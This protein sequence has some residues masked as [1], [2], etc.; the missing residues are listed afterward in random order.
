MDSIRSC[1]ML[2]QDT[3]SFYKLIAKNKNDR[4][5]TP[6]KRKKQINPQQESVALYQLSHT[7]PNKIDQHL[8]NFLPLFSLP[9][10]RNSC[11]MQSLFFRNFSLLRLHKDHG[12]SNGCMVA[13]GQPT[14]DT[15]DS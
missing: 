2:K 15:T 12:K 14:N 3:E 5:I 13:C 1:D 9:A 10:L 7:D 4:T 6:S 11:G 8:A